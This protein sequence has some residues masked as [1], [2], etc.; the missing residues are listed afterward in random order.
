MQPD[1][2]EVRELARVLV[3]ADD[4]LAAAQD[5]VA[6][7]THYQREIGDFWATPG[8]TLEAQTLRREEGI[9]FSCDCDD[10]TILL[11]SIL[12]NYIPPEDVFCAIGTLNGDGHMFLVTPG[13]NGQDKIIE[14]TAP[15]S[16]LVR[17]K[18][19]LAAIFN[20]QYCF[21]YPWGLREFCLKPV[22][23]EER[24]AV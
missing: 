19:N 22:E 12:R 2:E 15:S 1:Q 23:K 7:F 18:Y 11:Y 20:D 8:E 16:R 17:G 24:V 21:S 13:E 6:S 3:Q 4:F 10:M 9:A 14:A 5:F